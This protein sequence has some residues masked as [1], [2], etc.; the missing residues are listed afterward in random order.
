MTNLSKT[1]KQFNPGAVNLLTIDEGGDGQRVDNYLA[2]ILKGVPK[3]HI[4][5]I[6]RSGEV[7]VNSKRVDASSK[8]ALGDQIR[9]PPVRMMQSNT[10][11]NSH[12]PLPPSLKMPCCLKMKRCWC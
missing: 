2:K 11:P 3:S 9:V 6:L 7:R 8:L 5:R 12:L 4:Y 1:S 10:E